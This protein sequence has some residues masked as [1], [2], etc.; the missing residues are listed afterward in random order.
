MRSK[1]VSPCNGLRTVCLLCSKHGIVLTV[2]E[3]LKNSL[4]SNSARNKADG[5]DQCLSM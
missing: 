2:T 1:Q 3:K 5:L 4:N